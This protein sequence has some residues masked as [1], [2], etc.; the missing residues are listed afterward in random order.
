MRLR[1][2]HHL[3]LLIGTCTLDRKLRTLHPSSMTYLSPWQNQQNDK[4]IALNLIPEYMYFYI[5]CWPQNS[6]LVSL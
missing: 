1:S 4:D 6:S 2:Y 3:N 5:I